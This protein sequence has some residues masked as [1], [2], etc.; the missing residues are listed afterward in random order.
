[1]GGTVSGWS[2]D[3][4]GKVTHIKYKPL[5]GGE[6]TATVTKALGEKIR[7]DVNAGHRVDVSTK[8]DK[9]T[10]SSTIK[11]KKR[12]TSTKKSKKKSS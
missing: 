4:S 8:D 3:S 7:Q 2:M 5:R 6:K 1:M 12:K 11:K 9:V 10:A